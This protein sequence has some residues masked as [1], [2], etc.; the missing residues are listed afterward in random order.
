MDFSSLN[1]V[2][3]F[4]IRREEEAVKTYEDLFQMAK[5]ESAR[6]LLLDLQDRPSWVH[7]SLRRITDLYFRYYDPRVMRVYLPTCNAQELAAMFGPIQFY[8]LEGEK[9]EEMLRF[10]VR[11]GTLVQ[12]KKDLAPAAAGR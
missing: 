3:V 11:A 2:I 6:K 9:P 4:A 10:A 1:D 7:S 8:V 12:H 5:D